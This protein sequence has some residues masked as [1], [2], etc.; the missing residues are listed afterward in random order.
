MWPKFPVVHV[1]PYVPYALGAIHG[2]DARALATATV[3][4][5]AL[6]APAGVQHARR[7]REGAGSTGWAQCD[8]EHN[9]A[10]RECACKYLR[11]LEVSGA[12]GVIRT[13]DLLV[14][15]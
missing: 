3:N 14:R 8:F 5:Q 7:D 13:P 1:P 6:R 11:S 2:P 9:S 4:H 12:P 10:N 15:S